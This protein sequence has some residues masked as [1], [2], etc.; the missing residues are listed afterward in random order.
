MT[1]RRCLALLLL[2]ACDRMFNMEEEATACDRMFNMEEEARAVTA[3]CAVF[4]CV[5]PLPGN[6]A[7]EHKPDGSIILWAPAGTI[8]G[9]IDVNV[10]VLEGRS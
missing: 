10:D 6:W 3:C 7:V 2:T 8:G 9:G 1:V 5:D 4:P